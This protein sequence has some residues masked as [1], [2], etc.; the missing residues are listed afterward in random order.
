MEPDRCASLDWWPLHELPQPVVDYTAVALDRISA[1]QAFSV[2]GWDEAR[3][4]SAM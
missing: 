3:A 2:V 1:R 4:A